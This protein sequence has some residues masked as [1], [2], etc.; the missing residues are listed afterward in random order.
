MKLSNWS[1]HPMYYW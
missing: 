1:N